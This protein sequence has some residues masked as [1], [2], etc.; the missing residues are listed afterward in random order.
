MSLPRTPAHFPR[1]KHR[2]RKRTGYSDTSHFGILPGLPFIHA[3][4]PT[5]RLWDKDR[6][7]VAIVRTHSERRRLFRT[8]AEENR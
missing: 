7:L 2:A 4:G 8:L 5:V 1:M 3:D 6:N